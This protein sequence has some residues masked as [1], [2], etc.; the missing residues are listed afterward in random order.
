MKVGEVEVQRIG[1]PPAGKSL[2]GEFGLSM[3][4]ESRRGDQTR[5]ML[6]DFGFTA[7]T[8]NNNLGM[9][10]I[11]PENIDALIL[12]HGHYD[13]FGGLV[14]FLQQNRGKL[15]ADLPCTGR[16]RVLLHSRMDH[17]QARGLRISGPQGVSR[18]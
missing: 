1:M 8:L 14:G 10:G 13:H 18:C 7:A 4:L 3:H 17:R 15:R 16:G 6:L 9:L 5:N 11:A 2:L 12:S